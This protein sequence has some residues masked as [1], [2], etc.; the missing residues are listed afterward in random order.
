M[1]L[2]HST[3]LLAALVV[4]LAI[5]NAAHAAPTPAAA[6]EIAH[7]LTYL[8]KS[9]CQFYRSGT[10]HDAPAARAH[11][12]MKFKYMTQRDMVQTTEDFIV[13]AA[14]SSSMTGGTYMVRCAGAEAQPSADWLR[15]E[16]V[17]Y[18]K[19]NPSE[20]MAPAR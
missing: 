6:R 16:L 19:A 4:G 5:Q 18:R 12:D 13:N 3:S 15:A 2:R 14:T 11:L 9:G 8:E 1:K 20:S 10:W 7:L 17:R